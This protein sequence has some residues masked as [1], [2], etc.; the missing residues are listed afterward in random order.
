M[1]YT[2]I[3]IIQTVLNIYGYVLIAAAIASWIPDIAR[4][5]LGYVIRRLTDPYLNLFRR[6]IPSVNLGGVMLDLGY[7]V[8]VIVYFAVISK[9]IIPI[10]YSIA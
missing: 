6:F 5:Q 4:T 10:L 1:W 3:Y 8:G 7:L 9:V 2:L